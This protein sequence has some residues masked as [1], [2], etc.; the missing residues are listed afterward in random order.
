[1]Q[2]IEL[3]SRVPGLHADTPLLKKRVELK[4]PGSLV[5]A[6]PATQKIFGHFFLTN[7]VNPQFLWI[8]SIFLTKNFLFHTSL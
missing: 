1:M 6:T 7:M 4:A 8:F 2:Q 3:G 5:E